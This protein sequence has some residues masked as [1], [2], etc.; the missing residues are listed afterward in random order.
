MTYH[1]TPAERDEC[2]RL[3]RLTLT[4]EQLA[5]VYGR[6]LRTIDRLLARRRQRI[7]DNPHFMRTV[8]NTNHNVTQPESSI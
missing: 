2:V 8:R 3:Y 7:V 1:M 4:R 6:D 5:D